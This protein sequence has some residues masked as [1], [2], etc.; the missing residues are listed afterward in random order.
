MNLP[1]I[2]GGTGSTNSNS[3]TGGNL[4]GHGNIGGSSGGGMNAGGGNMN[5]VRPQG[6]LQPENV[7]VAACFSKSRGW[8]A[9][10]PGF[11]TRDKGGF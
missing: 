9:G 4:V 3:G 11:S 6:Q 5:S 1:G 2:G 8:V 7:C 10:S